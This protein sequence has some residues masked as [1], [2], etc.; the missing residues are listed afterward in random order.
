MNIALLILAISSITALTGNALATG[1][2]A[3][4]SANETIANPVNTIDTIEISEAAKVVNI[5][6]NSSET[7]VIESIIKEEEKKSSP[8]FGLTA[9]VTALIALI[10]LITVYN[11]NNQ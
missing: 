10:I 4:I 3:N 11:R 9:T 7:T 8:G 1:I 2:D 5:T 6:E